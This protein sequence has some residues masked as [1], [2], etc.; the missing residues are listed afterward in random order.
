[1]DK[2]DLIKQILDTDNLEDVIL[3]DDEGKEIVFRQVAVIPFEEKIYAILIPKTAV[4]G[5]QKGEGLLFSI[6][7]SKHSLELVN[8]TDIIDKVLKIYFSL[9]GKE[10]DDE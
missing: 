8:D 2:K 5:V 3:F 1:M 10:D 7:E 9:I 6:D 4:E